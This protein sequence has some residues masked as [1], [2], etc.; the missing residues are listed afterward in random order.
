MTNREKYAKEIL[1]VACSGGKIALVK[2]KIVDCNDVEDCGN[3]HFQPSKN[4]VKKCA[5]SVKMWANKEYTEPKIQPAI[6][7]LHVDDKVLVSIDG[8]DW[9]RR[10]FSYYDPVENNVYAFTNGG[11]SWSV[12]EILAWDYAKLPEN[13]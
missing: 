8:K 13:L 10:Y 5:E 12:E 2:R 7:K 3:C 4:G 6:E 9:H 11:T 1:D